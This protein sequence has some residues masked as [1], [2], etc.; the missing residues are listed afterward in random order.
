MKKGNIVAIVTVLAIVVALSAPVQALANGT[1]DYGGGMMW[2]EGTRMGYMFGGGMTLF[3]LL[4]FGAVIGLIYAV[5]KSQST[6]E[7]NETDS[8]QEILDRRF[9]HGEIDKAEYESR[10]NTLQK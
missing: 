3:W 1:H 8:A 7:D 4:V 5:V 6:T 2:G 10:T 9:A